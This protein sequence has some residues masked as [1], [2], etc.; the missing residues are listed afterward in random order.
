MRQQRETYQAAL[1]TGASRGL[2]R[3]FVEA[4]PDDTDLV[5]TARTR[6]E[7]DAVA[8]TCARPGRRIETIAADLTRASDQQIVIRAARACDV[9]LVIANA[10]AGS[11]GKFVESDVAAH[12][13]AVRLN[14][15]STL[16]IAHALLP[17]MIQ[18]AR[19]AHRRAGLVVVSSS[20]AFAPVPKFAVYAAT[21]SFLLS[22]SEALSAEHS[23]DPVNILA[24]CPG[25]IRTGFGQHA[26]FS[27]GDIP[28]AMAP[29]FAAKA[30]LSALG[31]KR[32]L[33]LDPLGAVPLSA[34]A[35]G[36]AAF[37]EVAGRLLGR[38]S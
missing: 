13:A 16:T 38:V 10:G 17:D 20:T 9:D 3:A 12:I 14:I 32:T 34:I 7:L 4:L 25:A 2:G 26:G 30:A 29:N 8:T 28:G 33:V 5:L 18:Q 19:A 15:E 36:R 37:A 11:F 21:K 27:G 24:F 35:L 6:D 1:V 31:R 23:D 22:W